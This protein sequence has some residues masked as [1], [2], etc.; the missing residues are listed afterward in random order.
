MS[1]ELFRISDV[2]ALRDERERDE[3]ALQRE[4]LARLARDYW[5]RLT[6]GQ[7]GIELEPVQAGR[8][9]DCRDHAARRFRYGSVLVCVH[10]LVSRA[11]ARAR[12]E[13]A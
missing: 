9:H 5:V 1:G 3:A 7:L 12:L 10:H 6:T 2:R 4:E 11:R 8:C 13:A